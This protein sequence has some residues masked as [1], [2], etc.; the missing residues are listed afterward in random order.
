MK[1]LLFIILIFQSTFLHTS[2]PQDPTAG[3]DQEIATQQFDPQ[4]DDYV[5]DEIADNLDPKV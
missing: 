3:N 4:G 1:R 2:Q 5:K